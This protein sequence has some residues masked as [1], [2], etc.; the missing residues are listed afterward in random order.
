[1]GKIIID[2]E[3]N[4]IGAAANYN[5]VLDGNKID[6]INNGGVREYIVDNGKHSLYMQNGLISFGLKSNI[7]EFEIFDS[8]EIRILC[9]STMAK[10]SGIKLEIVSINNN[11]AQDNMDKYAQLQK[12]NDLKIKNIITENEYEIQKEKILKG[13]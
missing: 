7:L 12:L 10:W 13:D 1:M 3:N 9:K 5:V 2:R 6:A 11:S 8:T 4:Y